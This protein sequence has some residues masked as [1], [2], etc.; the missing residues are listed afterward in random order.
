MLEDWEDAGSQPQLSQSSMTARGWLEHRSRI[1]QFPASIRSGWAM[2]GVLDCLSS[3]KGG[4]GKSQGLFGPG[5]VRSTGNR[6][7]QFHAGLGVQLGKCPA[8]FSLQRTHIARNLGS[9]SQQ[10]SGPS[11]DGPLHAQASRSSGLPGEEDETIRCSQTGRSC[12]QTP[13]ARTANGKGKWK[14]KDGKGEK[15]ERGSPAAA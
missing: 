3:W 13:E 8:I 2:A 15:G 1:Q 9:P 12:R 11:L 5:S 6:P 4:R 14:G 7:R 10:D